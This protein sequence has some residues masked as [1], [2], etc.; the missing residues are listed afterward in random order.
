M[1]NKKTKGIKNQ[2]KITSFLLV[3]I[4]FIIF[5]SLPA[6]CQNTQ[7]A[8]SIA[9]LEKELNQNHY[10]GFQQR[11]ILTTAQ[12]IFE[13]G[14]N[15]IE[16]NKLLT[17]SIANNFDAYNIKK[18]LEI[19][20]DAKQSDIPE[21]SLMN[22]FKEGLSK[23]VEERL[24]VEV[25]S[26]ELENLKV[27]RDIFTDYA[28]KETDYDSLSYDEDI[29]V[30]SLAES[31]NNGVP[32]ESLSEVLNRSAKQGRSL[33]EVT[34][35]STELGILSLH[36]YELGFTAEEVNDVF[37]RAVLSRS[38]VDGICEDIQDM[39]VA[40]VVSKMNMASR[41][42]STD[43][44]EQSGSSGITTGESSSSGSIIPS[45]SGNVSTPSAADDKPDSPDKP[46]GD[47]SPPEN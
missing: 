25:M 10:S 12:S 6:F 39:I 14:I 3:I 28:L 29:I 47:S 21:K 33:Q 24:I 19:L 38:G 40:A 7:Y 8:P 18:I 15:N 4:V 13:L 20:I 17:A 2:I 34:E 16:L 42:N 26:N 9:N 30:E 44:T 36:A 46:D 5:Y 11:M 37:E 32:R 43:G 45:P 23:R 31:L 35:V 41:S 1:R 22:K 27:A